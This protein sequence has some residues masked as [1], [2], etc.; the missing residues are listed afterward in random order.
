VNL[1]SVNETRS[2]SDA[3]AYAQYA[4][5]HLDR[6]TMSASCDVILEIVTFKI[7]FLSQA[8]LRYVSVTTTLSITSLVL[9]LCS[10]STR[11]C[12]SLSS[13][14]ATSSLAHRQ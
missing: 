8:S 10:Y 9:V 13:Y 11:Q 1:R 6:Q 4:A 2:L 14:V 12:P 3:L 7:S 5:R